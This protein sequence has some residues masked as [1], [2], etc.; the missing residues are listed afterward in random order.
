MLKMVPDVCR[1]TVKNCIKD[2]KPTLEIH[3]IIRITYV[4]IFEIV[5]IHNFIDF[6]K[7]N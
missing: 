5:N 2:I 7:E 4:I 6:I 3:Y 1:H